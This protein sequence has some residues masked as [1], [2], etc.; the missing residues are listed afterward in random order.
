MKET[1]LI[2]GGSSTIIQAICREWIRPG[3]KFIFLG[4]SQDKIKIFQEELNRHDCEA[5]FISCDLENNQEINKIQLWFYSEQIQF[6]YLVLGASIGNKVLF[7]ESCQE[8]LLS[9]ININ[10]SS[11]IHLLKIVLPLFDSA[12]GR[13]LILSST[14]A[15]QPGPGNA[16]YFASKAFQNSLIEALAYEYREQN[17][18]FLL[19]CPGPLIVK[20][21]WD[22]E[23][24]K[25]GFLKRCRFSSLEQVASEVDSHFEKDFTLWIP[26]KMNQIFNLISKMIPK[27]I[28]NKIILEMSLKN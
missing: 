26:G 18:R 11:S 1:A 27:S 16:L 24:K 10:I 8:K 4:R 14:A 22:S 12:G 20:S 3:R 21:D 17:I 9:L 6:H 5:I 28:R 23:V 25:S 13:I 2:T 7:K 19:L 15:F